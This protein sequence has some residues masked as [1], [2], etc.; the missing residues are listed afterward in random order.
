[1]KVSV[2]AQNLLA[3]NPDAVVVVRTSAG[4]EVV[5]LVLLDDDTGELVLVTE[6]AA[7]EASDLG[8]L[9]IGG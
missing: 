2:L 1:M 6:E 5:E 4:D 9:T 8:L 3:T 7:D